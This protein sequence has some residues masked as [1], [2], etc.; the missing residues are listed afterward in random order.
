MGLA[1]AAADVVVCRSGASTLGE[2]PH[3]GLVGILV[4]YPYAWRYQKVNA[5]YLAGQGAAIAMDDANMGRDLLPELLKL[6]D[7][8]A[9]LT[10]MQAQAK[11]LAQPDAAWQ[12]AQVLINT[13]KA[14]ST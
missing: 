9:H 7:N 1:F 2:L 8:P 3:F 10:R 12:I 5:D 4:P 6:L 13:G 14:K 11:A